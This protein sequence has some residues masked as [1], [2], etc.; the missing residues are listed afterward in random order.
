MSLTNSEYGKNT[1]REILEYM[2][3]SMQETELKSIRAKAKEWLQ[4]Y[5]YAPLLINGRRITAHDFLITDDFLINSQRGR[6]MVT[7]TEDDVAEL[8][9]FLV[10][11]GR[12]VRQRAKLSAAL[13]S[14]IVRLDYVAQLHYMFP[15]ELIVHLPAEVGKAELPK[16]S[17]LEVFHYKQMD[18]FKKQLKDSYE[19]ISI[20]VTRQILL[21]GATR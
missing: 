15:E 7:V 3:N 11:V 14:I 2:L 1:K 12:H 18:A 21:S 16:Y 9:E 5:D 4:K 17:P 20:W 13:R 6:R 8:S 10:F 19:Q